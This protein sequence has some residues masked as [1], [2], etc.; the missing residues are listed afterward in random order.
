VGVGDFNGDG[1]ADLAVANGG[2]NSS[3]DPGSVSILLGNGDGTFRAAV[4]YAAGEAPWSVAV[5]DFNGDGHADLVVADFGRGHGSLA[6]G[7]LSVLLGNGDGT[8]Q[9]AQTYAGAWGASVAVKDFNGDGILD[10]A[11]SGGLGVRVLL[12][13][14]DGTFQTTPISY[15]AGTGPWGLAVGDLN[16]DGLPDLAVA[17]LTTSS[18]VSILINDGK[19]AP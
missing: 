8:F 7:T 5:G 11:V 4:N 15:I 19:W 6:S 1:I 3:T 14:G 17:D 18:G 2:T 16:G 9:A 10:L 12:G 13:N